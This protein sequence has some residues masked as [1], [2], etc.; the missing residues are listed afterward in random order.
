MNKRNIRKALNQI[1]ALIETV[2]QGMYMDNVM[3]GSG[4]CGGIIANGWAKWFNCQLDKVLKDS[5]VALS[6]IIDIT[7][8]WARRE[9]EMGPKRIFIAMY[10]GRGKKEG[11][12]KETDYFDTRWGSISLTIHNFTRTNENA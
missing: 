9:L 3:D 7:D 2:D 5:G 12:Y 1:E 8:A 10:T 4:E 6:E 11:M